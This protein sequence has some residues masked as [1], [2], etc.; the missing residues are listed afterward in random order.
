MTVNPTTSSATANT[1][2]A[3]MFGAQGADFNMFL[4]LL[5]TQMQNQDPL[6]PMDTSQYTQQLVQYS[7]VEQSIQQTGLLRDLLARMS[8]NDMAQA[9]GLIGREVEFDSSVAGLGTGSAS[10]S[11]SLP[12]KATTISGEIL[13]SS[14]RVVAAPVIDASS[15]SGRFSWDGRLADGSR[16]PEGAYVLRLSA[17]D[18]AGAT[19]PATIHSVGKVEQVVQS[20]GEMWLGIGGASLPISDLLRIAASPSVA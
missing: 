3:G 14:G 18:S 12:H 11:W 7:Q 8:S 1:S 13:D 19:V 6:D 5:T 10:W 9:S 17:K 2:P 20:G 16:A 4:K 15:V